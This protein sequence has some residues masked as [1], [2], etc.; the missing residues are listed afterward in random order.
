MIAIIVCLL[1]FAACC[2]VIRHDAPAALRP[3]A[4][5]IPSSHLPAPPAPPSREP[6]VDFSGIRRRR[7]VRMTDPRETLYPWAID[8]DDDDATERIV[9]PGCTC[10]SL[11]PGRTCAA[12]MRRILGSGSEGAR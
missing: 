6:T 4:S 1:C 9:R 10:G 8:G 2:F 11:A 7:F 5:S 3:K 12:C